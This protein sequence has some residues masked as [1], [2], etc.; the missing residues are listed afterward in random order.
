MY[1]SKKQSAAFLGSQEKNALGQTLEEFL[2]EY[3]PKLFDNPCNTVDTL[4][5]TYIEENGEKKID[6]LLLIRR[7]NH[8]CIG[9]WAIPGG[10]V[11]YRENLKD[12]ALRELCE[13][14]GLT[15]IR[16]V[17]LKTYGDYDRD[18]RTRI[19]TTAFAALVKEEELSFAAGDDA[20]DAALFSISLKEEG[21]GTLRLTLE[22]PSV[23]EKVGAVV[24]VS[25]ENLFG[26]EEKT[27]RQISKENLNADHGAII[28][29][30]Y[31]LVRD[32]LKKGAGK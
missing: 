23:P 24:S 20:A 9:F 18:P 17:T 30:S 8:P 10:F 12:A 6:K 29:E 19:I 15:D 1:L 16:P 14:T 32:A 4:V 27:Y 2:E 25:S 7:G 26:I 3:D 11:E 21:D 5:F 31:E 13:E 28:A 22:N